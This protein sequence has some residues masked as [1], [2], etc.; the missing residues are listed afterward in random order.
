MSPNAERSA[1]ACD[2]NEVTVSPERWQTCQT[3]LQGCA[4]EV[5]A[6]LEQGKL[7]EA[8]SFCIMKRGPYGALGNGDGAG[9]RERSG[10]IS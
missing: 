7:H 6:S 2:M 1:A 3:L 10:R 5:G 4:R 9:M 8:A